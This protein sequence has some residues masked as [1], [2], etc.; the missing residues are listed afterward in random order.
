MTGL[1]SETKS[2]HN[3]CFQDLVALTVR[4]LTSAVVANLSE[5]TLARDKI[6]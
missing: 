6:I 1:K 3:K 4:K 2:V 5:H